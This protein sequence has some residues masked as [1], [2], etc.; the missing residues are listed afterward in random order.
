MFPTIRTRLPIF[1]QRRTAFRTLRWLFRRWMVF[2]K[3]LRWLDQGF[4]GGFFFWFLFLVFWF[5]YLFWCR[6]FLRWSLRRW[7][8]WWRRRRRCIRWWGVLR[9]WWRRCW[10]ECTGWQCA[11]L[12]CD[13]VYII[14][15]IIH[16]TIRIFAGI[17]FLA[18]FAS[19]FGF[20][21]SFVNMEQM[22][23]PGLPMYIAAIHIGL[24]IGVGQ[25][26]MMTDSKGISLKITHPVPIR[27]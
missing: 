16:H 18:I 24:A 5:Y 17:L 20:A 19:K 9:W 2:F 25:H 22:F 6:L 13:M 14:P 8:R 27:S 15:E 10:W 23:M 4:F 12:V 1:G 3:L 21:P 7:L 11:F 26:S